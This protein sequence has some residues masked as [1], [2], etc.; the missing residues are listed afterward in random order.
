M[1][2]IVQYIAFD[3]LVQNIEPFNITMNDRYCRYEVL[4]GVLYMMAMGVCGIVLVAL[5]STLPELTK[6]LH[7]SSISVGSIFIAR[8]VG[9]II[10]AVA[11]EKLFKWFKGTRIIVV[12]LAIISVT[13]WVLPFT[14]SIAILHNRFFLMGLGTSITDTGT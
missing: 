13:L 9:A 10:G 5:G 7:A 11:S 12:S 8:G 14:S 2:F 6:S 3:C 1:I 4:W